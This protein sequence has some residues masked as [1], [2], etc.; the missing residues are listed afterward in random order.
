MCRCSGAALLSGERNVRRD[1]PPVFLFES[2]DDH[3]ISPQN[4]VLFVQARRAARASVDPHLLQHGEHG[5]GLAV[6]LPGES[7]W[8]EM[9]H[10]WLLA[11]H[12]IPK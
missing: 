12:F 6:G 7:A 2:L 10:Q 3:T 9:F 1:T 4:S 5:A 8:P 11:E